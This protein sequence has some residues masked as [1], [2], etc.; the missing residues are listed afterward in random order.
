M[1]KTIINS[2]IIKE[3]EYKNRKDIK[4]LYIGENVEEIETE[5]FSLCSNLE[6]IE[7]DNNNKR[8]SSFNSN[9]IVDL[10]TNAI[11]LGCKNTLIPNSVR[12]I[13][14]FA[15]CGQEDLETIHIPSNIVKISSYAFFKCINAKTLV[16]D[17]GLVEISENAFRGCLSL[18]IIKMPST[19]KKI[20]KF[21]FGY[22][23]EYCLSKS[24]DTN[25]NI[26]QSNNYQFTAIENGP[27]KIKEIHFN[28]DKL[29][30][31]KICDFNELFSINQITQSHDLSII[32]TDGVVVFERNS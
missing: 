31:K 19:I 11:I 4:K 2:K 23:R 20:E 25:N 27:L 16:I 5:A 7:V 3:I 14:P 12:L 32:C 29:S 24:F 13:A 10:K 9:C 18:E 26:S 21:A 8:F 15:F 17:E 22:S 28:L 1:E 6:S 30:V